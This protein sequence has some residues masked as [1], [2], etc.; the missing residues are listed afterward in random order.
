MNKK[1]VLRKKRMPPDLGV[2]EIELARRDAVRR[3]RERVLEGCLK[4][5][6]IFG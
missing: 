6:D 2:S 5:K 4:R 1:K 3:R